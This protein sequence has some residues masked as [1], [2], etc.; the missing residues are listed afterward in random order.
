[1]VAKAAFKE[2]RKRAKA[3]LHMT[4]TRVISYLERQEVAIIVIS[5]TG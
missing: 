1:M 4:L 2:A 3:R 5:A